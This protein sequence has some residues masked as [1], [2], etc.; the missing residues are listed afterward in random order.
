MIY[1]PLLGWPPFLVSIPLFRIL[2][3]P[4][5]CVSSTYI[6]KY[7]EWDM[8]PISGF[9]SLARRPVGW[10]SSTLPSTPHTTQR[11]PHITEHPKYYSEI[12]PFKKHPA[13]L[14]Y[15]RFWS[16]KIE[17]KQCNFSLAYLGLT[18]SWEFVL[19]RIE[20]RFSDCFM[21]K[22]WFRCVWNEIFY[23]DVIFILKVRGLC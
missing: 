17:A 15:I 19:L 22:N 7:L 2:D 20:E 14:P 9:F 8:R 12:S 18:C 6:F 1:H 11:F 23:L 3:Y 21:L 4:D 5:V 16:C 13:P 10:G